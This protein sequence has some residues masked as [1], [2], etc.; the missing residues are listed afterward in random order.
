[1]NRGH[2]PAARGGRSRGLAA[3]VPS[4][5]RPSAHRVLAAA[6]GLALTAAL[7]GC[8]ETPSSPTDLAAAIEADVTAYLERA[9]PH[10]RTRAV[11]VYHH[12]EPVLERYTGATEND[13]WD[14]QSVTKSVIG[15]LVGIAIEQGRLDGVHQTLGE[16]LPDH[17]SAMPPEVAAI[18]LWQVLTHT[19]GM[20][21][22]PSPEAGVRYW[23]SS[24]WVGTILADR[25]TRSTTN[26]SFAY[27]NAGSHLLA[28]ILVEATGHSVLDY[29]RTTLFDPLGI[30]STPAFE[31]VVSADTD[32]DKALREYYE[33]DFAWPVDPLGIH[34][35]AGG[36]RLRPVDLVGIGLL[37]LSDGQWNGEQLVPAGWVQA[38][39][40]A[41]VDVAGELDYG[42]QWWVA[43][44]E[45]DAAYLAQG[46]GGQLIAVVPDRDLVVVVAA[47][48][49]L[50][51]P[52]RDARMLGFAGAVEL[53]QTWVAPRFAG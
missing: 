9:D 24:D 34:E 32:A 19:G 46:H 5:G 2:S 20:S 51:D 33:G 45:G 47:E 16:L 3:P 10:G 49:D 41:Q 53:F 28:A 30:P 43:D 1:M 26:G 40:T 23:E 29:A 11:L 14:L 7:G 48:Y 39:T 13:Y 21:F 44:L 31:P 38:S 12:G 18:T 8:S 42:Y 17:A 25:A 6:A 50:R 15:T 37:Y 35:G 22:S 36:L 27:S 52:V 4:T